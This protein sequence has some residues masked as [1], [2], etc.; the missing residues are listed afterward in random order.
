VEQ[1]NRDFVRFA[2]NLAMLHDDQNRL[3][4]S[5]PYLRAAH[6]LPGQP[7]D[8][9]RLANM[10][11]LALSYFA[12]NDPQQG[13]TLFNELLAIK[14]KQLGGDGLQFANQLAAVA[15]DLLKHAQHSAAEPTLSE[16]LMI[17]VRLQPDDWSTFNTKA[18]LGASLL[19][20]KK[21]EDAK[22]FLK[23]GYEGMLA[24]EKSMPSASRE[25]L[26]RALACLVQLHEATENAAEAEQYRTELAER[27]AAEKSPK[28]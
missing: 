28:K 16:C 5:L 4:E 19:G 23:E 27:K 3:V 15:L 6:K 2:K 12:A 24:R 13:I 25:F 18:L 14:R 9:D 11:Y 10:R 22:P 1:Y 21:Y 7:N 20:Q 26:T 8:S 17:R